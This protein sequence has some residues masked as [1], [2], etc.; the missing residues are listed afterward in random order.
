MTCFSI[1]KSFVAALL[2]ALSLPLVTLPVLAQSDPINAQ[3]GQSKPAREKSASQKKRD[4]LKIDAPIVLE[5]FTTSDCTACVF[6]DRILYDSMKNKNVIALSCRIK[7]MTGI[8]LGGETLDPNKSVPKADPKGPMDPCVFRLWSYKPPSSKETKL[9]IPNFVFNGYNQVYSSGLNSFEQV[10]YQYGFS[11]V[12]RT[13]EVFM[14]WKDD[15]TISIHMPE[16]AGMIKS[17]KSASVWLV[18]YK[19]MAVEKIDEGL[20]KGRV[21]RFS[22]I[23]QDMKHVGKW[24]GST[25]TIEVDVQKPEGGKERGGYVVLTQEYMGSPI[26]AAGKL[27]DYPHPNDLKKPTPKAPPAPVLPAP[28]AQPAP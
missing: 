21:L 23:V 7:D 13:R 22:N 24:H 10:M 27:V 1:H 16:E 8:D 5:L 12:N 28:Q 3:D 9:V 11:D 6:A 14:R 19:D 17:K 25:R 4:A 26:L 2:L 15:D 18:R 20:N